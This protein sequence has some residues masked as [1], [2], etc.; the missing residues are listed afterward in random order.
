MSRLWER[1]ARP[2]SRAGFTLIEMLASI[3]LTSV[4]ISVA[5]G[6]YISLSRATETATLRL[7]NSRQTATIIDRVARD[8]ESALLVV[9]P[10][11]TDPIE[12]PWLFLAEPSLFGEGAD[13]VKFVTRNSGARAST[14]SPSDLAVVSYMLEPSD[15]TDES[16]DLY[17]FSRSG[18]PERLDRDFPS[19]DDPG[20][21]VVARGI[22]SFSLRFKT[23]ADNWVDRWDSSLLT[24]SSQL[25]LEVE[26]R[27]AL[28]SELEQGA[29][30]ELVG[31]DLEAN[32]YSRRVTLHVRPIDIKAQIDAAIA[33][34]GGLGEGGCVTVSE[35][36]NRQENRPLW[37]E[38][39]K[40]CMGDPTACS[41]IEANDNRCYTPELLPGAVGC[42][43]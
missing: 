38:L 37:Q 7:R 9:K 36:L 35:C 42:D 20:A 14:E 28:H 16:F 43:E 2:P 6:F 19:L 3:F 8:F 23:E 11:E 24:G 13:R 12:H 4:V 26:I 32:S 34:G 18:L 33:G 21:R 31:D 30:A 29:D 22:R 27:V 40:S 17:R 5:V 25:P 10:P 15:E 1:S 39:F 41:G